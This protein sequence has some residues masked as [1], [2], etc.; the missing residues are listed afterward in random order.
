MLYWRNQLSKFKMMKIISYI[1]VNQPCLLRWAQRC[2]S[3][4]AALLLSAGDAVLHAGGDHREGH[5]SLR[6]TGSA[7]RRGRWL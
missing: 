5:G 3:V 2:R 1:S 7:H 6:L 4:S